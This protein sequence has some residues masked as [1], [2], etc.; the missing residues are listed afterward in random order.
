MSFEASAYMIPAEVFDQLA[1][2]E[3]D[4]LGV[5][6]DGQRSK[7]LL[8]LGEILSMASA[9]A[10]DAFDEAEALQA[11]A[12]IS[13][14]KHRS[15]RRVDGLL[16]DPTIGTWA[17][18]CLRALD[19]ED[20]PLDDIRH[21]VGHLGALAASAALRTGLPVDVAV[22][23]Q[24]G[25]VMLPTLG[26]IR[27]PGPDG[28]RRLRSLPG[29][30]GVELA[31]GD[32]TVTVPFRTSS[33][34]CDTAWLPLRRLRSRAGGLKIAVALDDVDPFRGFGHMQAMG[35]LD[36]ATI[37]DWQAKLDEAWELLVEDDPV[38]A[39]AIGKGVTSLVPLQPTPGATELSASSQEAN[40]A[41]ALTPPRKPL[42]LALALVH[43]FQHAK[44]A[45]L[46]DLVPL[47]DASPGMLYYA[48]WRSD[49]RPL[50][51]LLHGTYAFLGLTAFWDRHRGRATLA[52]KSAGFEF[53]LGRGQLG[54]TLST[55]A[56]EPRLQPTGVRFVDGLRHRISE[57]ERSPLSGRD[58]SL[59]RLA[60]LDHAIAWHL[61]NIVPDPEV[62]E[63][64]AR[65]WLNQQSCPWPEPL[66]CTFRDGGGGPLPSSDRLRLFR[67]RAA[68]PPGSGSW[69]ANR[70]ANTSLADLLLVGGKPA[71][72]ANAYLAQ[73][74]ADPDDLTSWSGLALARRLARTA[75]SLVF[76]ARPAVVQAA[77]RTIRIRSG[78]S[79]DV[80][81]LAQWMADGVRSRRRRR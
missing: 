2:G 12:L 19:S 3:G 30:G 53:A 38:A 39:D 4:I 71:N 47:L 77:H 67:R 79:P 78:H 1:S 63:R 64:M 6:R 68:T 34:G 81:A 35:R 70:P 76:V 69:R 31:F 48:P 59:A 75:A 29:A 20:A 44:L 49:P 27:L 51:A 61:C 23:V 25:S 54:M 10:P 33:S 62:V 32:T 37:D 57:L 46:L 66:R 11:F 56:S 7:R 55:L 5:L 73:L 58:R 26:M 50:H 42:S 24:A 74:A 36:A 9:R 22:H 18:S 43:E 17:M 52:D 15:R 8:L 41:V 40:G 14:A 16:L 72:A 28:W 80:E 45:A 60:R 13:Q 65:A 21:L